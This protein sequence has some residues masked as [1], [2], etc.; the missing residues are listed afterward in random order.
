MLA[1]DSDA[2]TATDKQVLSIASVGAATNGTVELV[3]LE[4]GAQQ[5]N[6]TPE[7]NY[8]GAAQFSYTV[9]DGAGGTASAVASLDIAAVNDI[10]V[11]TGETATINEDTSITFGAAQLL[12]ND[13]DNDVVTDGQVLSI[14]AV[15]GAR[16]GTVELVTVGGAQQVNFTPDSNYHGPAQFSYTVSD[17]Q[18]GTA[19]AT[20]NLTVLAVNDAPVATGETLAGT[21]DTTLA[22][23]SASVL[24]NDSDADTAT[25]GQVLRIASVGAATHGTVELATLSDG[26]QQV[27]FAPE[28]NYHGVA[29]FGY[30]VTDSNGGTAT[31][32]ASLDFAAVNDI[33]VVTGE[34]ATTAEDTA[35]SFT[36]AQLLSNDSDADTA[37]DKQALTVSG[38]G[39]ASHGTVTLLSS[40]DVQ[41]TP[42]A[43]YH[44]PAQFSYTVSDGAGGTASATVNI[45]V[46][47]VNDV[48]VAIGESLVGTE[49][50]TLVVAAAS[51]LANDSDADTA[52]DGQVL[53][54]A[55]VGAATH[56][57]V[58]LVT[59]DGTQQVNFRPEANYHGVAQFG[60]TVS[61]GA[62]G[63]ASAVASL[64]IAAV[65]DIPVVTGETA[66]TAEDTAIS[67][68]QAQ[69]L[70]NDSDADT[71][72]DKQVLMVSGVGDA[73]NGKV[74]LLGN[75]DIQFTP[76]ANY[77]G[78]A[79]FSYT[80]SDG[81][82]GT[83]SATVN[84]TVQSVN[85]I[86]VAVGEALSGTEDTTLVV[87]A[88][89]L[90]ANDS[91]ADTATDDQ[92]LR[93]ESVGAA[94]HG[95]VELLTVDGAQQV[96]FT[97]E[98]N[99]QGAA[100]FSYTVTDRNGGTASAVASLDIAAV[101]D[102]PVV[103]GE[104]AT[105][106]EDNTIYFDTAALLANDSD[107]DTLTQ[108]QTLSITS[109]GSASNGE[110]GFVLDG[111][112][113]FTPDSNYFG[114]ASFTYTVS[115]GAGGT[116]D[117]TV[118]L[119]VTPVN[120]A[121]QALG[122]RANATEDTALLIDPADLLNNDT[123]ID[124]AHATLTI[125][126]V[127]SSQHGTVSLVTLE[128]GAQRI[129]FTPE[130]NYHGEARFEYTVSDPQGLSSTAIATLAIAG[131]NDA[132][133]TA[134]ETAQTD[135]DVGL[136][137]TQAQLLL[138]DSDP[139]IASDGDSLHISRV[140]E[141]SHG[142]VSMNE[143]HEVTF[144]PEA[145]YHGLAQFTYWVADSHEVET[146]AT[147]SLT[148]AAVNDVPVA[149]GEQVL[150][151]EDTTLLINVADLLANDSDVDKATDG[152]VLSVSAVSGASHGTVMLLDNG[153]IRFEPQANYNG[154]A[155]FDYTVSDGAGGTAVATAVISLAS[156]ND[157]PVTV[158]ESASGSEDNELLFNSAALLAND[159]DVDGDSLHLSRVGDASN[160]TVSLDAWGQ[161]HFTP[162]ANYHGPAKFTYWVA[163]PSG[164]ETPATVSL[165]ITPVND[166]PVVTGEVVNGSEDTGLLFNPATLLVNDSDVDTLTD[167]QVL[168]ISALSNAQHGAV[169]VQSNGQIAFVPD[170]NFYGAASFDYT[171]SDGDGDGA[172]GT[173]VATVTMNLAAVNDA[174]VAANVS[175]STDSA[176][177]PLLEDLS[178]LQIRASTLLQLSTDVD[179]ASSALHMAR[180][181]SGV[182]GSASLDA[183]GN[184]T[185]TPAANFNGAA[186]FSYWV[187]DGSLESNAAT[188][189]VQLA[190]V[191]DAP[192][193]TGESITL[194]EDT[195]QTF[196]VASL[197]GNDADVD[198]TL[199]Q[200]TI[201]AVGDAVGGTVSLAGSDVVFTPALNFYGNAS[202]HYTVSDNA[203][204]TSVASVD[205]TYTSV[206]DLPITNNEMLFG[207][208]DLSYTLSKAALL[209]NDTD[210]ETQATNLV[211][212][213]VSNAQHGTVS[214][215]G[216]NVLF[217]PTPGYAG[218]ASFDYGVQDGDGGQSTATAQID[219]SHVNANPTA[220]GDTFD[221]IEDMK[222]LITAADLLANDSDTDNAQ[223]SLRLTSVA[224]ATHGTVE[225]N[226]DGNAV[227]TPDA[228]Y[229]GS[230]SFQYQ[231]SDPDGGSNWATAN[232]NLAPQ[233][234]A[235]IIED[236]WYGRPIFGYAS[237]YYPRENS[238]TFT[239][240]YDQQQA[241]SLY[242]QGKLLDSP[243]QWNTPGVLAPDRSFYHSGLISPISFDSNDA[244]KYLR[245]GSLKIN[246]PWRQNGHVVAYDPDGDSNTLTF[247]IAA[248][249]NP[250]HGFA[251]VN[252]YI[253]ANA[254]GSLTSPDQAASY[255]VNETGAWQY[256][257]HYG[258][259]FSGSDPFQVTVTDAGLKS[260]TIEIKTT[261]VGS[262]IPSGGKPV[263]LDLDGNGLSY[264]GI[265]DSK[266]YFDVN[267]DGWRERMAWVGAGDG[268]LA[269][270]LDG[271]HRIDKWN[272]ISFVSYKEGAQTDLEGLQAFDSNHDGKLDHLDARWQ[273]FGAWVDANGDGVC[274]AGE[275]K[276]LDDLE[277]ASISLSSD[278]VQT[279]PA[280][281]V[282]QL[283][284]GSFSTVDGHTH[285]LGDVAFAAD[286]TDR[287]PLPVVTTT[288][289][290]VSTTFDPLAAIMH[291]ALS[292]NQWV[293]SASFE[294]ASEPPSVFV[295]NELI[296]ADWVQPEL[297]ALVESQ[298]TVGA[299]PA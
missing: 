258:D 126:A 123:D 201:S 209:A 12:A 131:V 269:L 250:E 261:H 153:T 182:G 260:T 13:T 138:N 165:T 60:Y 227:F 145:N 163:D 187:T 212:A 3:T 75:G 246:D 288:I 224:N 285:A 14:S 174:P 125:T 81:A 289:T 286:L 132:P 271:D 169:S 205:L 256:A 232:L 274:D 214:M 248:T 193:V 156:V 282:T 239:T 111:R 276:N 6:F 202:F 217:T 77:H 190:P 175:I 225:L 141:A 1:N 139:D 172:G 255:W 293:A 98:G 170:S 157:A 186:T 210:V 149:T 265:D 251:V 21:E 100:Q 26:A 68:T 39:D 168:T 104:T 299:Q 211:L 237:Q 257:S 230:A 219:F 228:N 191:N 189:T 292:F 259:G 200:L 226:K 47:P 173:S 42:D 2:D 297:L 221:G 136:V 199:A 295:P 291:Q 234:D 70:S 280:H 184:V 262:S 296:T 220:L 57:T 254:P 86:P 63:T 22:I 140:G 97:P 281:G 61:D 206:N 146:A 8:H 117:G 130:A 93:I 235:P 197:L 183:S 109:V 49:D 29:Q 181:E 92:V 44:G 160:G 120:D 283:G 127:G 273:Q 103:T 90:L 72:T 215:S 105:V 28:A 99:Y 247:S 284:Q 241:T 33:P 264:V 287:S 35:I 204:G 161:V 244:T 84:L 110:A 128:A 41:F 58:E 101:N 37:T 298:R 55:S 152:Q 80:V 19:S 208:R 236:V 192:V 69:L 108:V 23:A 124:N 67:F 89:T 266:A 270:D 180:V 222:R 150:G 32:V 114:P 129:L 252:R 158:S 242:Q 240:I 253:S 294:V 102:I 79:Q 290:E 43:N 151:T 71:A 142:D 48:P 121:P 96:I 144:A 164:A 4:G 73:S 178:S 24:A 243:G 216:G 166:L 218:V 137:F 223:T 196:S 147:V 16:N 36:Q 143:A 11:V 148:I 135:E 185:F 94:T 18:G 30:T 51:L 59:V 122:E 83:A 31:A 267:D 176:G 119:S 167:G 91:D 112:I 15:S 179:S 34:T 95:A 27:N 64:D 113:F 38:V 7:A 116:A 238:Y 272:E 66:T 195:V 231:V 5:V 159:S 279:D 78:P 277:I 76:D 268:L 50:T 74:T 40:G 275:F 56:G 88:S 82:G 85:D 20:M 233:N 162:T 213:S 65:N 46:Q 53:S 62:G 155:T 198:N 245:D 171:V 118:Q 229:N 45:T 87:A 9:S 115:D 194:K 249:D 207:K 10:P 54:I 107:V 106:A 188:V 263:T 52:T 17:G 203:G 133:V 278:H 154:L 177:Q 25:D 134:N